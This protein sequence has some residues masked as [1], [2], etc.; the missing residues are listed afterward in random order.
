MGSS[1]AYYLAA[2][3]RRVALM[4]NFEAASQTSPRAAGLTQQLR[5]SEV[6][7]RL[8]RRACDLLASFEHDTGEPMELFRSGSVKLARLAEHEA[9]LPG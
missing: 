2:L 8:A 4:D 3:G 1:V 5:G 7:S 6:M 9:Q